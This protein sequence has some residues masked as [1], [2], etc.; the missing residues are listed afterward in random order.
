MGHIVVS[1]LMIYK[2][3]L[4]V[5]NTNK[6]TCLFNININEM[7]HSLFPN[8]NNVSLVIVLTYVF[9]DFGFLK[10]KNILI[11][12]IT[13]LNINCIWNYIFK[14]SYLPYIWYSPCWAKHITFICMFQYLKKTLLLESSFIKY[15][16][17]EP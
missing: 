16:R 8:K 12:F 4:N 2:L 5:P 15:I 9:D 17:F 7:I 10:C 1:F 6:K 13:T 3:G 11:E 14:K